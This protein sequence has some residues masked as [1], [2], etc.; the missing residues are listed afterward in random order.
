[1]ALL[2]IDKPG[3]TCAKEARV[4]HAHGALL[5]DWRFSPFNNDLL[6]TGAE[7]GLVSEQRNARL[8]GSIVC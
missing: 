8:K 3:K 4:F 1:M 2:P 5:S 7:D 6:A